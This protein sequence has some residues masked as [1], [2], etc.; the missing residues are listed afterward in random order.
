MLIFG[1]GPRSPRDHGAAAPARCAVCRNEAVFR[2]IVQRNW[3]SLFFVPVV[4]IGTIHMLVCP[5]CAATVPV[6]KNDVGLVEEIVRATA[7]R[8]RGDLTPAAY[9]RLVDDFWTAITGSSTAGRS[10]PPTGGPPAPASETRGPDPSPGWYPDPFGKS[11][12][13]YWDGARWTAGTDP[14]IFDG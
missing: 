11:I 6:A 14:P 12:R 13:R 9:Q 7:D 1:Y 10:A 5:I 2:H 8:D 4:P 3:F